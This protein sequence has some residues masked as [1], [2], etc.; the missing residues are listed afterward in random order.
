[1]CSSDL[2]VRSDVATDVRNDV[3]PDVSDPAFAGVAL[4]LHM[5]GPANSTNFID[6]AGHMVRADGMAR[7]GTMGRFGGAGLFDGMGSQLYVTPRGSEFV[8]EGVAPFTIEAWV[9][10]EGTVFSNDS[11]GLAMSIKE[12]RTLYVWVNGVLPWDF[13]GTAAGTVPLGWHHLAL[14][15]NGTTFRWFID[16][17]QTLAQDGQLTGQVNN[18]FVVGGYENGTQPWFNGAMDEV[19]VTRGTARYLTNFTPP[20]APFPDR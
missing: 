4:L 15:Y 12:M 14:S 9:N 10:G 17:V 20:G 8:F 11:F 3:A 18:H 1:V 16:G 19:R 2:D 7:I 13:V 6:V 5:D